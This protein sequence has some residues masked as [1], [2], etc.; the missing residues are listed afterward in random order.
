MKRHEV[1]VFVSKV[2]CACCGETPDPEMDRLM[3]DLQQAKETLGDRMIY[4][5]NGLN[6]L[7]A[8][9]DN[10]EMS[11]LLRSEG[12][13]VLPVVFLN[14]EIFSKAQSVEID[15]LLGAMG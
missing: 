8:F 9:R 5:V 11:A 15:K 14:G 13:A 4:R 3:S 6:N 2:P 10:P 1:E 12:H 7:S